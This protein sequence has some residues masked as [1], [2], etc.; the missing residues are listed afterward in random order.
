MTRKPSVSSSSLRVAVGKQWT[1]DDVNITISTEVH[2]G[3]QHARLLVVEGFAVL[4]GVLVV[5]FAVYGF[6]TGDTDVLD[7]VWKITFL[8]FLTF[9]TWALG[10]RVLRTAARLLRHYEEETE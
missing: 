6:A 4:V 10:G 1:A 3:V 8:G 7:N 9:L 5:A 2:G